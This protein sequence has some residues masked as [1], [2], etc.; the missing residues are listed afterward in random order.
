MTTTAPATSPV[1]SSRPPISSLY[2]AKAFAALLV[3]IAHIPL[4]A[5]KA[6]IYPWTLIAVPIFFLISG[7]F[8]YSPD[9]AK[10]TERTWQSLKKTI[11]IFLGLTLFYWLIVLPNHGNTVHSWEQIQRFLIYGQLTTVHLWFLMAMIQA[12]FILTLVFRWRLGRYIWIFVPLM[13]TALLGAKYSFLITGG[14]E[15]ELVYVFNSVCYALPFMATGY[16]IKK[17]E[18][19]IP[20]CFPWALLSFLALALAIAEQPLLLSVGYNKSQGPYIGSLLAAVLIFI[21]A[22][23]HKSFG[24]GTWAETIGAKYSG[25]IYYFHIAVATII[26]KALYATGMGPV[27]EQLGSALVFVGNIAVAYVIVRLQDKIGIHILK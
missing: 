7:Y 16:L 27:Y 8:L 12:L 10:S 20:A 26:S 24:A 18:S 4:G 11:P 25:N 19:K 17:Y 1:K 6:W 23:Q 9:E 21:W 13:L 5:L 15:R 22:L 14:E 2:V 3:V